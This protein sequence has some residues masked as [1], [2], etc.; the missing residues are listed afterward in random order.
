MMDMTKKVKVAMIDYIADLTGTGASLAELK[1]AIEMSK[2]V[3]DAIRSE[4]SEYHYCH[5]YFPTRMQ[6]EYVLKKMRDMMDCCDYVTVDYLK[7]FSGKKSCS[8][9]EHYPQSYDVYGW[10]DLSSAHI[11]FDDNSSLYCIVLPEVVKLYTFSYNK[12][13]EN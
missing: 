6:A 2:V 4:Q 11:E 3:M 8:L 7:R 9:Y 1:I 13:K 5:V 12:K 10:D